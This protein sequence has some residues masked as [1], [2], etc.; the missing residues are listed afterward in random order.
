MNLKIIITGLLFF[1]ITFILGCD[2]NPTKRLL[3]PETVF[4]VSS[5]ADMIVYD[6]GV[7][8]GGDTPVMLTTQEG[9]K[10][11]LESYKSPASG[12]MCLEY[13][14]DGSSVWHYDE[15]T[16]EKDYFGFDWTGFTFAVKNS[17]VPESSSTRDISPGAYTKISFKIKGT[18]SSNVNFFL[19]FKP[20]KGATESIWRTSIGDHV[21]TETWTAYDFTIPGTQATAI[22]NY[23]VCVFEYN[24][25]ERGNGGTVYL[26]DIKFTK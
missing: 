6:E 3:Q 13:T 17:D 21:L 1:S 25:A 15:N 11:T 26:D 8:T 4:S 24:G 7:K 18:L 20:Y 16:G 19:K 2:K 23:L 9:Q 22:E 10:V 12:V 5:W 14:W